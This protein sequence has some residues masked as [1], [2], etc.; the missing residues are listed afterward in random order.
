MSYPKYSL[1]VVSHHSDFK[2]KSLRKYNVDGIDTVGAYGNE[3]FEIKFTNHTSQRIQVKISL[4]GTDIL[5]GDKAT[6]NI[7]KDMWVVNGYGTLNLRAWPETHN[8]GAA[9]I[10]TNSENSVVSH[11]HGDASSMGIIAAAIFTESHV[12]PINITYY[13]YYPWYKPYWDSYGYGYH[14]SEYDNNRIYCGGLSSNQTISSNISLTSDNVSLSFNQS[15]VSDKSSCNFMNETSFSS[16]S[17]ASVG[18]GQYVD[19]KITHVTGLIKPLFSETIRVRYLWWDELK[20]KLV[21]NNV[22]A[23][24]ASGFPGDKNQKIMNLGNTPR[25]GHNERLV[26]IQEMAYSRI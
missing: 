6:T 14:S 12:D 7:S 2:N 5:T 24:H 15:N 20:N 22:P 3:P 21:Q 17:L 9:F 16:N 26:K 10:F 8:G 1:D 4:D 19:Q 18:A 23:P 13:H 25:I 11:T